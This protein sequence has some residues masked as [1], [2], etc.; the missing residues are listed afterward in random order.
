MNPATATRT[1]CDF[2]KWIGVNWAAL[3]LICAVSDESV[4]IVGTRED[5][6]EGNWGHGKFVLYRREM[7]RVIEYSNDC[8]GWGC[9]AS[10]SRHCGLVPE[11]NGK[12]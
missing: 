9:L 2:L 5:S 8:S 1:Q 12:S 3:D 6:P 4:L 7:R 10:Q 11:V